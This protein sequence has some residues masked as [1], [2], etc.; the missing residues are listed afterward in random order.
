M[1]RY[2]PDAVLFNTPEGYKA[3][4]GA[5][6]NVK[7]AESFYRVWPHNIKLNNTW[8]VTDIEVHARK[9]RVLNNAFS[10]RALRGAEP[11]IHSNVDRWL[12][13]IK[14]QIPSGEEWS[15]SL[16]MAQQVNYLVYD[17]LGDLC[18]GESFGMK[19]P[20]NRMRR[21]PEIMTSLPGFM[22]P[23]AVSPWAD[24]WVWMKPYGLDWLLTFAIPG[25]L[26]K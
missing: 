16:N 15:L 11:L 20:D 18:F 21:M 5:K 17:I 10:D 12:D 23:V 13:L 24:W 2:R 25:D 22:Y 1:F 4:Y 14:T 19:E 9:R 8:N 7:K 26:K 6:G 3:I